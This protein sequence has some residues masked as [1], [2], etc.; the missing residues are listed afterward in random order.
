MLA[1]KLFRSKLIF[2]LEGVVDKKKKGKE[3]HKCASTGFVIKL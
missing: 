1:H 2:I 3:K